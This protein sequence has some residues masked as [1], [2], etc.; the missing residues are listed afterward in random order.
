MS[1]CWGDLLSVPPDS[2]IMLVPLLSCT[3]PS[4]AVLVL[5]VLL[6]S[7]TVMWPQVGTV[8]GQGVG[9]VIGVDAGILLGFEVGTTAEEVLDTVTGG[10]V[11]TDL[12]AGTVAGEIVDVFLRGM[13]GTITDSK[14]DTFIK[15]LVDTVTRE[16]F[17]PVIDGGTV[18]ELQVGAVI[19]EA[20]GTVM[21]D[22]AGFSTGGVGTVMGEGPGM[23]WRGDTALRD[24]VAAGIL[25]LFDMTR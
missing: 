3:V 4:L 22:V 12:V 24:K 8:I 2:A 1:S 11:D 13:V 5:A 21:E 10:Q 15:E 23:V 9:T 20:V 6:S 19:G 7:A 14:F 18:A 25:A 17:R 16:G